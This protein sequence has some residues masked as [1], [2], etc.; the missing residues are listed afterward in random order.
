[1]PRPCAGFPNSLTFLYCRCIESTHAGPPLCYTSTIGQPNCSSHEVKLTGG[2]L[3][4]L[5]QLRRPR[6]KHNSAR[7]TTSTMAGRQLVQTITL[8]TPFRA[9]TNTK[10]GPL[11][12]RNAATQARV[13]RRQKQR[14]RNVLTPSTHPVPEWPSFTKKLENGVQSSLCMCVC[15]W[16]HE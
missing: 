10:K 6:T 5:S 1:M 11:R 9:K 8:V 12:G 16:V 2:M 13:L 15:V 14:F 7:V 4:G 3:H